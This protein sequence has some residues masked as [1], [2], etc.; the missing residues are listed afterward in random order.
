MRFTS[1]PERALQ[2]ADSDVTLKHVIRSL[3]TADSV[4]LERGGASG[5]GAIKRP[6]MQSPLGGG[7]GQ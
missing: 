7:Y 2:M 1:E 6:M 5:G 3:S 4:L